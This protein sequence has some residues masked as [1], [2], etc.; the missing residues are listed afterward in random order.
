ME[1]I[2]T[3]AGNIITNGAELSRLNP[4]L[5]GERQGISMGRVG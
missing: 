3:T 4:W 5:Q 2:G 1:T